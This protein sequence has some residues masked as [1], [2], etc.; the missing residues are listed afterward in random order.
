MSNARIN[1][2]IL[3][4]VLVPT[5]LGLLIF[6]FL[7]LMGR[8]PRLMELVVNKGVPLT[9]ILQLFSYMLPNFFSITVPLSFLLGILLAF[10][11]LSADSEFVALKASG[12]SLYSLLKP[13]LL[14]AILF[15]GGSYFLNTVAIPQSKTEFRSKIFQIASS[16]ASIGIQ[17]GIFNDDFDDIVL[18]ASQIDEQNGLM[19]GIFIS[20]EREG[21]V[22]AT[23]FAEQGRFVSYPETYTLALRLQ[24]GSIHRQ[25]TIAQGEEPTYQTIAF[26]NYDINLDM[27]QH[28]QQEQERDR[29]KGELSMAELRAAI[30][31]AAGNQKQYYRLEGEYY[32]R[33]VTSFTPLV[34][35]LV[36]VPLGLQSNRSGKGSGFA[37]ALAISLAYFILLS[38][39]RTLAAKGYLPTAETLWL[40]NLVFLFGG[41]FFL[42]RTAIERPLKIFVWFG[43]LPD[44]LYRLWQKKE[45]P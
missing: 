20:D 8:I 25:P 12:I 9:D 45:R 2:Y 7:L 4:E 40:S 31:Q 37:L 10:G 24:N 28:L 13:V 15:S 11:R 22:P 3:Y 29:S 23:I 26:S 43:R 39:T 18:Y 38:L 33:I 14:L 21:T 19:R 27:G 5:L 34:F 1:R 35:A 6:T 44:R 41:C 16:R 42:H 30:P 17:S 32:K 36:G